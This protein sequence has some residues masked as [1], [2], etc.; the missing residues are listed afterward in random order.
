MIAQ[1]FIDFRNANHRRPHRDTLCIPSAAVRFSS[2]RFRSCFVL[3]RLSLLLPADIA[4]PW[5]AETE[6]PKMEGELFRKGRP[7]AASFMG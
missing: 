5:V 4:E 2:A 7:P 1:P 6:P 3:A